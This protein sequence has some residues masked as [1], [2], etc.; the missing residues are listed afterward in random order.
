MNIYSIASF[1]P[2]SNTYNY[3]VNPNT[4]VA[5]PTNN[6]YQFQLGIRYGF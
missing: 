3:T 4:G 5:T 6:P 1:N 2:T